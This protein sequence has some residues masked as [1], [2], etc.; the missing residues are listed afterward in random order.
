MKGK[1]LTAFCI[2][3]YLIEPYIEIFQKKII[4]RKL[5]SILLQKKQP[6]NLF[7]KISQ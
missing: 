5:F 6:L 1:N 2:F 7:P 3:S 4:F